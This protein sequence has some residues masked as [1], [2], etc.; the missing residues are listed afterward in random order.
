MKRFVLALFIVLSFASTTQAAEDIFSVPTIAGKKLTFKG[1]TDGISV[2]PY[3]GKIVFIEFWG[4]WCGPCLLSIPHHVKI[5]EKYKN[6]VKIIAIE[7]TPKVTKKELLAFVANPS[8]YIDMKNVSYFLKEKAKTAAE[9]ASLQKPI[10]ELKAFK[11]SKKKINYDVV[12]SADAQALTTY[13]ARR[14]GWKGFI[15]FLL[16]VDGKG[17]P[18]AIVPGMPSEKKLESIVKQILAKKK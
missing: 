10:A 6:K 4:T 16:V 8:K 18:A 2:D 15:P 12:A 11:A 5:Q 14:T 9:K 3:K 7:T 1:T 17:R 13:I